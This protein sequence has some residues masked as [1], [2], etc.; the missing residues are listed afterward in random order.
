MFEVFNLLPILILIL[1]WA[2]YKIERVIY[3]MVFC[4]PLAIT[5][6]NLGLTEG[7]DLSLPTEPL[8]AGLMVLYLLNEFMYKITPHKILTHPI[9]IIIFIQLSWILITTFTSENFTISIKFFIARLWFVFSCYFVTT[10]LFKNKKSIIPFVLAYAIPLAVVCIITTYWHSAFNFDDKIADWIVSPFYNDHTAY[11]A[12]LAMYIPV[13]IAMLFLTEVSKI[14]KIFLIG[15]LFIFFVGLLL[16]FS[17][18]GWLS[19]ATAGAILVSFWLRIKIRTILITGI[20]FSIIFFSFQDEIFIALGRNN[21][22]SEGNL[23]NTISSVTNISTDASNLERINRW[24]CAIRMFE[25]KPFLGWGPGTYMFYYAPFQKSSERTIISTNFGTNGNAHSEYLGPLSE[26]GALGML[27]VFA[28]F[29][30]V[31]FMGYR[32]YYSVK[33]RSTRILTAGIF[34]GLFPY[35]IH[36]F[37]NNFLDTD[38]LSVP[39]WGFMAVLVCIDVYHRN[40]NNIEEKIKRT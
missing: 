35:F 25:E 38:K 24:S 6:K 1:Y 28:L 12:A 39:F 36:G 8:M 19:L 34:L 23:S 18:G 7:I 20:T 21:T 4:T 22:D 5:L 11:G 9:T 32:L 33:D 15:L 26:Q 14:Q 16:S 29:F 3:I 30:A 10:Q 2:I 27:I 17:R 13:I 37:L 40:G 31:L